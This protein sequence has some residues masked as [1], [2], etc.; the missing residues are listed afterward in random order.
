MKLDNFPKPVYDI[1]YKLSKLAF[2]GL[3]K[4]QLVFTFDKVKQVCPEV[5]TTPGALNGFGLLQAVQH[6]PIKGVGT[7]VSFN[8]LHLTMQEFLAVWYI[9]HCP[10]EQQVQLL[11]QSFMNTRFLNELDNSNAHMWQMYVEIVGVNYDAWIKFTT[12]FNLSLDKFKDPLKYLYYIQCLLEG[13]SKKINIKYVTSVF[14]YNTIRLPYVTLLPYHI[15]LLCV[16]LSKS[17][18]QWQYLDCDNNAMGD[19]GVKISTN[20][21]LTNKVVLTC[22]ESFCLVFNCLTSRSGADNSA[23]I[24]EGTLVKLDLSCNNLGDR[25]MLEISQG[26]QVNSKLTTLS[27]SFNDIGVNGAKSLA[28]ALCH[29]HTLE[30]L[31]INNNEIM[32]DGVIA[33]SEC[34]KING[35]VTM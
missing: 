22:I 24:Q 35:G 26:L 29:N 15:A 1:I 28:T 11:E 18:E 21:L 3:L 19:V 6:Y 30:Y 16:F 34:F 2:Q 13:R 7:T 32:D 33:I 9:S 31:I 4:S 12:K 5:N 27:L 23:I 10:V 20:F 14:K 25:G 17:T 8:F